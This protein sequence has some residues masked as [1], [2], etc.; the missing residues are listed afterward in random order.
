MK[1]RCKSIVKFLIG[2]S[3]FFADW[4]SVGTFASPEI[5]ECSNKVVLK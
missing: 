2:A 4:L 5:L 3:L 1:N